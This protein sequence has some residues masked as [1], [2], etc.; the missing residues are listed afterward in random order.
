MEL[1]LYRIKKVKRKTTI[2]PF[3]EY[4]VNDLV[5]FRIEPQKSEKIGVNIKCF[6]ISEMYLTYITNKHFLD[7]NNIFETEEIPIDFN[8]KKVIMILKEVGKYF[9]ECSRDADYLDDDFQKGVSWGYEGAKGCIDGII[10]EL[11]EEIE[12]LEESKI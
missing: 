7:F 1:K 2:R 4:K 6:N 10:E 8:V 12:E 9:D 3:N 5:L 11:E